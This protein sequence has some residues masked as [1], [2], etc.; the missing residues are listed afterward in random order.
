DSNGIEIDEDILH[1]D[2][3][4]IR[5][6]K[7]EAILNL[8]QENSGLIEPKKTEVLLPGM[9][10][11]QP[12]ALAPTEHDVVPNESQNKDEAPKSDTKPGSSFNRPGSRKHNGSTMRKHRTQNSSKQVRQWVRKDNVS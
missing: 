12:A 1:S 7:F 4:K 9:F 8:Q 10:L 11:P 2:S 6:E 3:E 5:R